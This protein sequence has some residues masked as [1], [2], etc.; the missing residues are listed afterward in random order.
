[1]IPG[2]TGEL[3]EEASFVTMRDM[4]AKSTEENYPYERGRLCFQFSELVL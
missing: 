4:T 1:M 2:L 3:N